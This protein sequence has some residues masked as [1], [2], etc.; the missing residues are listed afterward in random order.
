MSVTIHNVWSWC[1]THRAP[2]TELSAP[3]YGVEASSGRTGL[4]Y[5]F[6]CGVFDRA[7]SMQQRSCTLCCSS[8]QAR[9]TT[10]CSQLAEHETL[11]DLLRAS[12]P[13]LVQTSRGAAEGDDCC[14]AACMALLTVQHAKDLMPHLMCLRSAYAY[15]IEIRQMKDADVLAA[16]VRAI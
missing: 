6:S 8:L 14:C 12:G 5:A 10:Q 2:A 9:L 15:S 1:S 7:Q 4:L 13:D 11:R 16:H 3:T